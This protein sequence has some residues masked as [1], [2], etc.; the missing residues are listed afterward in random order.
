MKCR[1]MGG[2]LATVTSKEDLEDICALLNETDA[3]YAWIGCYR[4]NNEALTWVDGTEV[5]FYAWAPGEPSET[6]AYDGANEDYLMLVRQDD[7]SWLYN[8]NRMDPFAGYAKYYSGV[9]AYVC[10][11]G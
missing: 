6:D 7:G 5:D 2:H 1:E 9:T 10:S 4:N 8:D 3:R 11:H